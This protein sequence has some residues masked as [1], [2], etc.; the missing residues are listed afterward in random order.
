M[1]KTINEVSN[2]QELNDTLLE[3][4]ILESYY[5]IVQELLN[6]K[7]FNS[8]INL[9]YNFLKFIIKNVRL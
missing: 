5:L 9:D 2:I 8:N 1:I 6:K 3:I 4:D 7:F